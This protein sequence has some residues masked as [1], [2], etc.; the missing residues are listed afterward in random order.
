MVIAIK[1]KSQVVLGVKC[2]APCL[3][4]KI[5]G[6]FMGFYMEPFVFLVLSS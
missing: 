5:T 6:A 2:M 1:T 4:L 3:V